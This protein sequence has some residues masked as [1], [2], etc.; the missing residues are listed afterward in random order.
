MAQSKRQIAIQ[1]AGAARVDVR[2]AQLWLDG[3]DRKSE[4]V[5][6]ALA[7]EA[8][9]LGLVRTRSVCPERESV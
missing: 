9:K 2:T 1:L 4:P 7:R 6:E 3:Q 5:N 8:E